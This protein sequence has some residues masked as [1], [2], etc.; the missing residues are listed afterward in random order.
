MTISQALFPSFFVFEAFFLIA[1]QPRES[2]LLLDRQID[3]VLFRMKKQLEALRG[4]LADRRLAN[5]P[6][7]NTVC[8]ITN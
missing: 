8:F 1:S 5:K 2:N 6:F 7:P 4:P 3:A